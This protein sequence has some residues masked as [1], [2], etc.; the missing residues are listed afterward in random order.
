MK[1]VMN[2]KDTGLWHVIPCSLDEIYFSEES[3]AFK[4]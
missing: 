4:L 2:M 3:A 1:N